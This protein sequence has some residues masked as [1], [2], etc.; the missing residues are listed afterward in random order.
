[1]RDKLGRKMSKQLGNSP[2]PIELMNKYGAD[3]VRMG[4][5]LSAPAGN[6]IPFDESLCEQGRNFC[7][8]IWNA[9]RLI[10][11][12]ETDV[13]LK[14]TAENAI[15][16]DWFSSLLIQN[17][18]DIEDLFSKYRLSDALMLIY[19]VFWDDFCSWY[20]ELIKPEYGKPIDFETYEETLNLF[21]YL[22]QILHPFMPFITEELYQHLNKNSEV[23]TSIMFDGSLNGF[24]NAYTEE[25]KE[26]NR[27]IIA[28]FNTA[29][30]IIA[31]IRTIRQQKNISPKETLTLYVKGEY[32][33]EHDAVIQKLGN[34][35]ELKLTDK[36]PSNAISYL[37]GTTEFSIPVSINAEE[38]IKKIESEIK[39]YEGFLATVLK[40]LSN[41]QFVANAKPE[42]VEMERKKQA[43]AQTKLQTLHENLEKLMG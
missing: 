36:K 33:A 41:E 21:E 42:V 15:A 14:K 31:G 25:I 16:I 3:G 28:N 17:V 8:K 1:V 4:M 12:W 6:D 34:I 40:K 11:G 37:V 7:N 5:M 24:V 30:E 2:D 35:S 22:L 10:Q 27:K 38:E 29:K 43:D 9:F 23:Q 19:K 26:E 13:K 32:N 18:I 20:L 39:Y